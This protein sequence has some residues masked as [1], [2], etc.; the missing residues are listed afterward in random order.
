MPLIINEMITTIEKPQGE[1]QPLLEATGMQESEARV[2]NS[3][4][5][6]KEREARLTID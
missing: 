3:L 6:S 5:L 2:V 1:E 4:E